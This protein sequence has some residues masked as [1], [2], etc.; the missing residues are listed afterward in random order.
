MKRIW[1]GWILGLLIPYIVTLAWTGTVRGE[2]RQE[3][4]SCGK[5]VIFAGDRSGSIDVE[6]YLL[7][8]VANQIPAD[9]GEE[10]LKAQAII[11]R[12]YI[13][14]QMGASNE[15]P[16]SALDLDYLE[17]QDL[18]KLWGREL[19][20]TYYENIKKAV[21]ATAQTVI[22][23]EGVEIDAL[24]H[25]ISAGVTRTGDEKHPYLQSAESAEDL[26]A[27]DYLWIGS[28]SP[29][30]FTAKINQISETSK[31]LKTQLPESIQM[32]ARDLTGYVEEIQIGNHVYT[33][34]EVALALELPSSNFTLE[35]YEGKIRAV[36]KG[37][38][39]G[40]GMS[41]YGAKIKAENGETAEE[42]LQ[43][44]YKNIILKTE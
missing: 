29:A 44:Y 16:E 18:E 9:Y 24:F 35:G 20:Q 1:T 22:T 17:E 37:S 40:Y 21:A 12:T 19:F 5:T 11:A 7:G 26:T 10:A 23:Y 39:H 4:A 32:I 27:E 42:I 8:I 6:N 41:Q 38:G 28:W 3:E 43:D 36:C 14:Q 15:I 2:I 13:Y 34:E 31:L 33:G 30:D 25:R